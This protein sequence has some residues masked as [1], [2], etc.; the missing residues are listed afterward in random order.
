MKDELEE[1]FP[2]GILDLVANVAESWI[3]FMTLLYRMLTSHQDQFPIDGYRVKIFAVG[4]EGHE[5]LIFMAEMF[6]SD[7][8]LMK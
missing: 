6:K 3:L 8:M 4:D 5:C 2:F 7:E 1:I